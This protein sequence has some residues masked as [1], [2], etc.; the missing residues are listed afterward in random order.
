[1]R[2]LAVEKK[3]LF[4]KYLS[5]ISWQSI[6][7]VIFE[8]IKLLLQLPQPRRKL[9]GNPSG[10]ETSILHETIGATVPY[11]PSLGLTQG[12]SRYVF[13]LVFFQNNKPFF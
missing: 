10:K 13:L 12:V 1:M 6:E 11:G 5:K 9:N 8:K 3:N 2:D 4:I 7:I